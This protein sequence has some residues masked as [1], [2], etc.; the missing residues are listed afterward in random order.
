VL[1]TLK[2]KVLQ[3]NLSLVKHGLVIFTWGNV[4]GIDRDKGLVVI[5]PSGVSYND[6]KAADMV[7]VDLEGNVVEGDL[8]PSSDTPTHIVLYKNFKKIGGIVH[9]HSEWATSWAQAGR[10]VP[11]YGTTHADYFYGEIPC[12]RKLTRKEIDEDY[13]MNTGKVITER[14]KELDYEALPG[15]L[16]NGHAPFTWGSDPDNAVHNAVVMEEVAKMAFR[17]EVLGNTNPVDMYLLDKHYRRKHGKKAYYGQKKQQNHPG[18][19]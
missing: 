3:A 10:P 8:N 5:K 2:E 14:F 15:V 19:S 6:M 16:V 1:K 4:S 13:E 17:T 18:K 7:I 12:T 9:T 11:A